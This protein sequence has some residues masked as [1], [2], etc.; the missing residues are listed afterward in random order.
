MDCRSQAVELV[1]HGPLPDRPCGLVDDSHGNLVALQSN[2]IVVEARRGRGMDGLLPAN[3]AWGRLLVY[4]SLFE[5]LLGG[6]LGQ[7]PLQDL[8]LEGRR[9]VLSMGKEPL[10]VQRKLL[11]GQP[12]ELRRKLYA[13]EAVGGVVH[14][15]ARFARIADHHNEVALA[16]CVAELALRELPLQVLA[17]LTPD[18]EFDADPIQVGR[19]FSPDLGNLPDHTLGDVGAPAPPGDPI[20]SLPSGLDAEADWPL[21]V[22][23][24]DEVRLADAEVHHVAGALACQERGGQ[25]V[26][27]Q[28]SPKGAQPCP[29]AQGHDPNDCVDG[30]GGKADV[31][32]GVQEELAQCIL[33]VR[34][35]RLARAAHLR[36]TRAPLARQSFEIPRHHPPIVAE[37]KPQSRRHF[38]GRRQRLALHIV[39][40]QHMCRWVNTV[41]LVDE[42]Q[43]LN[44]VW[45]VVFHLDTHVDRGTCCAVVIKIQ[46]LE[47]K[48]AA[49]RACTPQTGQ[50]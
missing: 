21:L 5:L 35:P 47:L 39:P 15:L 48:I 41:E 6:V 14:D 22:L 32:K 3:S 26:H 43:L 17:F 38:L 16:E 2:R 29:Q 46:P 11:T 23:P 13:D 12:L 24:V 27:H 7:L 10:R 50:P 31:R 40:K 8:N 18:R 49:L 45:R 4:A 9:V 20:A 34:H 19:S 37:P 33:R 28:A 36:A 44:I 42:H 25:G 30:G 1:H